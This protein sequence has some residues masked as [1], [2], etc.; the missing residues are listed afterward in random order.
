MILSQE[1]LFELTR[2][3]RSGAQAVV[4]NSLGIEHRLRPDGSVVVSQ[5]H[6]EQVL[7]V[8][9]LSNFNKNIEPNWGMINA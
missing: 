1:Q 9:E 2:K 7:G 3:K 8:V 6:V 4:L 5:V